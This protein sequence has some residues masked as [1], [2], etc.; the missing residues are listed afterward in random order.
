MPSHELWPFKQT[1]DYIVNPANSSSVLNFVQTW[2]NARDAYIK[3]DKN[4]K[5]YYLANASGNPPKIAKTRD[6]WPR[7]ESISDSKT[8]AG[9]DRTDDIKKETQFKT[10]I[11]SNLPAYRHGKEYVE[12][13]VD[14][15]WGIEEDVEEMNGVASI[16]RDKLRQVFDFIITIEEPILRGFEL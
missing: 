7:K 11:I 6:G 5:L 14:M 12:P 8:S 9:M 10:A 3:R 2:L 15:L 1:I 16:S 13:F 4:Q